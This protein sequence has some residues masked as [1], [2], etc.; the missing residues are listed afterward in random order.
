MTLLCCSYEF[1]QQI[2]AVVLRFFPQSQLSPK[3]HISPSKVSAWVSSPVHAPVA[4]SA[5][6]HGPPEDPGRLADADEG[7]PRTS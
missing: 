7:G 1:Y 4:D 5:C 2:I 3:Q 6:L